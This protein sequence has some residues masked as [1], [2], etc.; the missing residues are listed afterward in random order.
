M[1]DSYLTRVT[2]T[3]KFDSVSYGLAQKDG[4]VG[5]LFNLHEKGYAPPVLQPAFVV[6]GTQPDNVTFTMGGRFTMLDIAGYGS[7]LRTDFRS[8]KQRTGL[9][10]EFY[11]TFTHTSKWF[12][13]PRV[14]VTDT[15]LWIYSYGD[16]QADYRLKKTELGG[17]FGYAFNRFTEIRGGY[18]LGHLDANLRFGTSQFPSVSGAVRYSELRFEPTTWTNRSFRAGVIWGS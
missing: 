17:D 7:E 4:E 8:R 12:Y 11:K 10:S 1:L 6:D 3:D 2:G 16:P 18:E 15:A 13:A 14:G 5:L 9:T